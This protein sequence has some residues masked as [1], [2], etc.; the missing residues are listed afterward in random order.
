M[1]AAPF[2]WHG[3]EFGMLDASRAPE[4]NAELDA[5]CL[6]DGCLQVMP[7]S[8]YAGWSTNDL[9]VWCVQRG[10]YCLPTVE[11]VEFI[12]D[13]IDCENTI[14]IG[15]GNGALGRGVG[16]PVTDS[17]QQEKA[18]VAELYGNLK[19][20]T[21]P[22]APDVEKLTALEA[23]EKH[24]PR[25]VLA[26]WVTHRW[27]RTRPQLRG[28]MHGVDETRMLQKKFVRKYIFVGHERVHQTKPILSIKHATHR[29]P[30]LYSR[31]FDRRDVVWVWG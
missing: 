13:Q 5:A 20:A 14:E 7:A 22:Y 25:V 19:Q 31:A 12:R 24:R 9:A 26:A 18:D 21:V 2:N 10:F 15:A 16:V 3:S 6:K 1:T 27:E 28:N 23:V 17:H 29:L 4:V 11:L 8:F 30:F